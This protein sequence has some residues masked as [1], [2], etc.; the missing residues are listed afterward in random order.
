MYEPNELIKNLAANYSIDDYDSPWK[1]AL[2]DYLEEFLD[3]YFPQVSEL[4]DWQI[5]PKSLDSEFQ[6][7]VKDSQ[8]GKNRADKLVEVMLK[9]GSKRL[10]NI[11][12]EVQSQKDTHFERRMFTYHYRIFDKYGK[13]PLSLAVLADTNSKWQPSSYQYELLNNRLSFEFGTVK[14]L[15]YEP[16][17]ESLMTSNNAFALL[18]AAHLI[19]K[20]TKHNPQARKESKL[21]LV[22]LLYKNSW[23]KEKIVKFFAILDWLMQLPPIE[24]LEFN[25]QLIKLEEEHKMQYITSVERIGIQKGLMQGLAQGIEDNLHQNVI[26]LRNNLNLTA[27]KIAEALEVPLEKI[28]QILSQADNK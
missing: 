15:N 7:V 16:Q 14:L 22:R 8:L 26:N 28:K 10:L 17:L 3:F 6:A 24:A 18:T 2:D 12:I 13:A 5:E 25:E 20:R 11:H 19:T 21:T 23:K 9:E 1:I 4:I 27:E